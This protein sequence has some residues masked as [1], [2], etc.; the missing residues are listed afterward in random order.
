[1]VL[2]EHAIVVLDSV[3][4]PAP[5]DSDLQNLTCGAAVVDAHEK[6]I[7]LTR[8]HVHGGWLI[9][10]TLDWEVRIVGLDGDVAPDHAAYFRL[11]LQMHRSVG[12]DHAVSKA[13]GVT[14]AAQNAG[15]GVGHWFF[16]DLVLEFFQFHR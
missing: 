4:R 5:L 13:A 14:M 12:K 16:S 15:D 3:Q 10:C 1:M 2:D 7:A 11:C 6:D 8:S 9:T